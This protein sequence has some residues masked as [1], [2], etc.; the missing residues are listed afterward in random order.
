MYIFQYLHSLLICCRKKLAF[1]LCIARRS[2]TTSRAWHLLSINPLTGSC[3]ARR[4][5]LQYFLSKFRRARVCILFDFLQS[6]LDGSWK[7]SLLKLLKKNKQKKY[8]IFCF[9]FVIHPW[10][11]RTVPTASTVHI[12]HWVLI[13]AVKLLKIDF[14]SDTT[15]QSRS[16]H[17]KG[18]L[19][20]PDAGFIPPNSSQRLRHALLL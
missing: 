16:S 9:V 7:A 14:T 20:V 13:T 4:N 11:K 15:V 12:C 3:L 19:T 10:K 18:V 1:N 2:G 8:I 5:I 17:C 6:F